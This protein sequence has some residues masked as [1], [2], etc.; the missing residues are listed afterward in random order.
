MTGSGP[1]EGYRALD[2]ADARGALAGRLLADLGVDVLRVEP[3]GGAPDRRRLPNAGET[4]GPTR[5]LAW[6]VESFGKRSVTAD[7]D[8]ADGRETVLRL[9]AGSDFVLES[10]APGELDRRGLGWEVLRR[11]H[12]ALILTSI[13]PFGQ[14]GPRAGWKATD[15]TLMALGGSVFLCGD[16]DRPP[17]R[18]GVPQAWYHAATE[19]VV[20][21]LI[22]HH[23]RERTGE[24]QWVDAS[25]QGVIVRSLMSESGFP[26]LH[27]GLAARRDGPNAALAGF[28]RRTIFAAKDGYVAFV[29]AGGPVGAAS[30][31]QLIAWMEEEGELPAAL[32]GRAWEQWDYAG[33]RDLGPE[34]IQRE[35]DSVEAAVAPF[36][37]ARARDL[38]YEEALKRRIMLAPLA[39]A[40]DLLQSVQLLAREFFVAVEQPGLG[41][42][43]VP[44]P[45]ARCSAT[46]LAV[47][48][49]P[50]PGTHTA[51]VLREAGR[52]RPLAPEPVRPAAPFTGLRV[53]DFTWA[54]AGPLATRYLACHGA[55]VIRIESARH[56]DPLR[57][58]APWKDGIPGLDR[59]HLWANY[60]AGKLGITLNLDTGEGRA[61]ARDL[62]RRSH[63]VAEAFTPGVMARWGLD[64]PVLAA[65]QPDLVMLSTCQQGQTGPH[66]G[67]PGYGTLMAGLAG[68]Y[69]VTGWPD[70]EPGMIYGA[71]TDFVA[72]SLGAIA[73]L[74]ALDYRR[75]T[76]RGQWIDLSQLEAGL[77]FLGPALLEA[78]VNGR[79]WG[80]RANDDLEACPHGT[81]R[82]A[83]EERWVALAVAGEAEWRALACLIGRPAWA[84]DPSLAT[85]EGRRA[86]AGDIDA[87]IAEWTRC[88]S[89]EVAATELQQ[90][91]VPAGEVL[92]CADLHADPQLAHA[93][94]F[95]TV[96]HPVMGTVPIEGSACRLPT[97]PPAWRPAPT[98]G[99]HTDE[100]LGE[101]LGLPRTT[102]ERLRARG[103]VW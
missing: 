54:A 33:L 98:W 87:A 71:Y 8:T 38:L 42:I 88:R 91:G 74:A 19:A 9:A 60:N 16:R 22:A 49:A 13:T 1:L 12:P 20:G 15:L 43:T 81:Y 90:V 28:R 78:S 59:S 5:S 40:P 35:F 29:L 69:S 51:E 64:Y 97:C 92:S 68:F 2:L 79:A 17:L 94:F 75:R 34:A 6:L 57:N 82:C 65:E 84:D 67:Y 11:A 100:V 52:R 96:G 41:R 76:G 18:I 102:V 83:G 95:V 23:W 55:E 70:R 63:V 36:F 46:P 73:L 25:G 27:G 48:P 56:R 32:R 89:P 61:L 37:A 4:P 50:L 7:L 31:R 85:V 58:L 80:R 93:G 53:V 45:F 44:G 47:R 3:P 66:A 103:V 14:T 99:E 30:M 39:E 10:G 24:G 101:L 72:C 86:Q 26:P 62:I 77:Q 21:T